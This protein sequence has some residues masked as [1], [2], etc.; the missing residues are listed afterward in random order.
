M[1]AVVS[2][3]AGLIV[4]SLLLSWRTH[5]RLTALSDAVSTIAERRSDGH[6]PGPHFAE[7][8]MMAA[9]VLQAAFRL[10]VAA[11]EIG[12]IKT[13]RELRRQP[14][15]ELLLAAPALDSAI[16]RAEGAIPVEFLTHAAALRRVAEYGR[17]NL[18][19]MLEVAPYSHGALKSTTWLKA[20]ATEMNVT[21]NAM[22]EAAEATMKATV[23]R[24]SRSRFRLIR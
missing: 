1:I 20:W 12:S 19:E 24:A 11:R 4:A 22:I 23:A 15:E 18:A 8:E 9:A 10:E 7:A 5:R 21:V 16:T 14:I 3:L 17:R 6:S 13:V 2:V